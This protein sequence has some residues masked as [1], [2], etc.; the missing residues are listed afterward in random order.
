MLIAHFLLHWLFSEYCVRITCFSLTTCHTE[1]N[2]KMKQG[3][4]GTSENRA[5]VRSATLCLFEEK[6]RNFSAVSTFLA[7]TAGLP[8]LS[9]LINQAETIISKNCNWP[10]IK[11]LMSL[12]LQRNGSAAR[13]AKTTSSSV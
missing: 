12:F 8:V 1:E 13:R 11:S 10:Q 9:Y 2:E 3:I 7:Q 4:M 6:S 5:A